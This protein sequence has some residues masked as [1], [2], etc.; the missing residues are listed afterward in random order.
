MRTIRGKIIEIH[1]ARNYSEEA[2][3]ID[4]GHD[5]SSLLKRLRRASPLI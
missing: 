3:R 5:I 1:V 4:H 2:G